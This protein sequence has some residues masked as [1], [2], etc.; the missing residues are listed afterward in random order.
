[1]AAVATLAARRWLGVL[2]L[3][4]RDLGLE[5]LDQGAQLLARP[6]VC[7]RTPR[8]PGGL[9][10]LGGWGGGRR[11]VVVGLVIGARGRRRR[12]RGS[13]RR[14]ARGGAGGRQA[15][16]LR[17][18]RRERDA[19]RRARA[20]ARAGPAPAVGAERAVDRRDQLRPGQEDDLPERER[21]GRC[22]AER[23]LEQLDADRRSG[24]PD[25]VDDDP[26]G[27]EAQARE[28]AVELEH[29][30]AVGD[31]RREGSVGRRA[32]VHQ[33]HRFP[34]D[35]V[36]RPA[37]LDLLPDLREPGDRAAQAVVDGLGIVIAER[38]RFGVGLGQIAALDGRGAGGLARVGGGVR[39]RRR[40]VVEDHDDDHSD[41]R[42]QR[43]GGAD[44]PAAFAARDRAQ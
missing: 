35:L 42:E 5:Q 28:V 12:R 6:M 19:R 37:G 22:L 1:M 25:V 4:L 27:V 16:E 38:A 30:G 20:A 29:V 41:H 32:A 17:P 36:Q 40:A 39:G 24:L 13:G 34:V 8:A 43:Q 2:L 31:P 26:I 7:P 15:H 3:E 9:A 33:G 14:A 21:A 10:A 11:V 23:L 44:A 18:R